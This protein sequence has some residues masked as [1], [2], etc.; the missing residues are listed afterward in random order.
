MPVKNTQLLHFAV[1]KKH[2][3]GF[4][5]LHSKLHLAVIQIYKRVVTHDGVP[6]KEQA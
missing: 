5:K 6:F 4:S 3:H 2:H 1:L